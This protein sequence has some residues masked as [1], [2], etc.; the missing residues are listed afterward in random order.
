M[1]KR[2]VLSAAIALAL[3]V[4]TAHAQSTGNV[5][6]QTQSGDDNVASIVQTLDSTDNLAIQVQTGDRNNASVLLGASLI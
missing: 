1:T 3:G 6:D 4:S 5:A 2:T